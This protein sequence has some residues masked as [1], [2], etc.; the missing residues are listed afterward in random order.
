M[1]VDVV[2]GAALDQAAD[3]GSYARAILNILGDFSEEKTRLADVQ[4][5]ML[6]ILEDSGAEK[7]RLEAAQKAT[8]NILA[9]FSDE[10]AKLA[11]IQKAVLNILE[12]F[13]GEKARLDSTQKAVLNILEDFDAEKNKV[14]QTN[15][16]MAR[17]IAERKQAEEALRQAKAAADATNRELEA[18]SYS[19]SHDLRAPLWAIDGFSRIVLE[20]YASQLAPDAQRYLRLVRAN[21]Q[22][23]G[24]LIDDLLVFSRLSRQS[25]NKRPVAPADLARAALED[26]RAEQEGRHIDITMGDL[27]DCQADAALHNDI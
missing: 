7:L 10:R 4:R 17:E 6:N 23:M 14:E 12:D 19:V 8:L 20:E 15:R 26:L 16:E 18:F 1:I 27:P 13:A 9:D 11:D 2:T 22:Q 25:L 21:T 24:R 3:P 5:A